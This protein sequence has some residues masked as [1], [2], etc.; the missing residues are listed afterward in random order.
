MCTHASGKRRQSADAKA[1]LR[2]QGAGEMPAIPAAVR[3]GLI[4]Y[5]VS[6]P[7]SAHR[8]SLLAI[9]NDSSV[10]LSADSYLLLHRWIAPVESRGADPNDPAA[11]CIPRTFTRKPQQLHRAYEQA[12]AYATLLRACGTLIACASAVTHARSLDTSL[13]SPTLPQP[14]LPLLV[15]VPTITVFPY[16]TQHPERH[17]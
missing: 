17:N 10:H 3:V 12:P 14:Q 13:R 8:Q 4:R 9:P 2:Q 11:R 15:A 5:P 6:Q 7:A 16:Y 1:A